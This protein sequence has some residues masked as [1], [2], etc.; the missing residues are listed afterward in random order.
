[1]GDLIIMTLIAYFVALLAQRRPARKL[2]GLGYPKPHIVAFIV[3]AVMFTV[4]SGLRHLCGDTFFYIHS[5]NLLPDDMPMPHFDFG[6]NQMFMMLQWVVRSFTADAQPFIFICAIISLVPVIFIIYKYSFPYDISMFLFVATGYF[7]LSM[8]G[9]RQYVA[10]GIMVLGTKYM[11]SDKKGAWWKFFLIAFISYL[12]HSSAI[13]MIPIFLI[14]RRKAWTPL[15]L[16]IIVASFFAALMFNDFLP[17]FLGFIGDFGYTRYVE[18]EWFTSGDEGGSSFARVIVMAFPVFLSYLARHRIKILGKQGDI[19][20]N[21]AVF[22][23]AFSI[24]SLRN[25]IFTRFTIYTSIYLI[26]LMAWLIT[27]GFN[28]RNTKIVYLI[29]IILFSVYFWNL[30]YSILDYWSPYF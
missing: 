24:L 28:K 21:L 2:G 29:S 7:S 13:I 9:M 23:L 6:G 16:T 5:Y 11:F 26:I 15:T 22:N 4:Y 10:A 25:W 19:L 3:P 1:M 12:F 18:N 8:N 20:I 30:R 14:V 17:S 27:Q